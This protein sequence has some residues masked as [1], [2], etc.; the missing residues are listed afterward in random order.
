LVTLPRYQ[1]MKRLE[2]LYDT[3]IKIGLTLIHNYYWVDIC[4]NE[5]TVELSLKECI[6]KA[7]PTILKLKHEFENIVKCEFEYDASEEQ[8]I[9]MSS[10]F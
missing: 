7:I 8:M 9:M 3:L 2:G 1:K 4:N 6:N 5:S 10:K